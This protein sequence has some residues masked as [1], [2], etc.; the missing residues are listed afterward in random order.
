MAEIKHKLDH[1]LKVALQ[2]I[3]FIFSLL[4]FTLHNVLNEPGFQYLFGKLKMYYSIILR[5]DHFVFHHNVAYVAFTLT[6]KY[7]VR[8]LSGKQETEHSVDEP[9]KKLHILLEYGWN[10]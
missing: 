3:A 6:F 8:K 1:F 9:Q 5:L 10:A 7:F 2:P 4:F